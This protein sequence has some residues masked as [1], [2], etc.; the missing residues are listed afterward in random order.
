[1]N[2]ILLIGNSGFAHNVSD[3]QTEKTR[4]YFN[5]IREEGFDVMFVDLEDSLKN[6][7]KIL[8]AIKSNIKKCDRIVLLAAGRGSRILIPYINLLN[9]KYK[10]IF[11]FPLIGMNVLHKSIKHLDERDK[12]DFLINGNISLCKSDKRM[13]KEL[14][15]INYILPETDLLSAV[16]KRFYKLEN[17]VTLNNFRDEISPKIKTNA[18]NILK[19]IFLSRV[20]EIKGVF[21]LISAINDI[22]KD[23]T[24]VTLDIYGK[25]DFKDDE[26]KEFDDGL[27]TNIKYFGQVDN[28]KVIS[29][30]S[31]YDTFVFPTRY[32]GEG[33]PGVIS[34]SLIAGTPIISSNFP[35]A[36]YLL[37]DGYDS[38]L[39]EMFDKDDLKKKI[40]WC[41][42]NKNK[43][44]EMRKNALESSAIY[45]YSFN[46][47][48]FLK[49]VCG[50]DD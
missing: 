4:L 25:T 5:K 9:K 28:S 31:Q 40:L 13:S 21:D 45:K 37:K 20:M 48:K 38:L 42:N 17:V 14:Q 6:L 11:V 30:L 29:L 34:E 41:V 18:S 50:K 44:I 22:N 2:K 10:K 3:G 49:Y 35:Q 12:I 46:R 16:F 36:K 8:I 19:L 27:N 7:L 15:K 26:F 47:D 32:I 39:F 24:L 23:K 33:T 43:L 1:M